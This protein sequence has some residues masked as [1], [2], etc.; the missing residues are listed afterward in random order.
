VNSNQK[1]GLIKSVEWTHP[2]RR[3]EVREGPTIASIRSD[4]SNININLALALFSDGLT[5][6][7]THRGHSA[8]RQ[9]DDFPH[10]TV[11]HER[12]SSKSRA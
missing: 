6:E 3:I 4:Y 8:L 5:T 2:T 9:G 7:G 1:I 11:D 12:R 10:A